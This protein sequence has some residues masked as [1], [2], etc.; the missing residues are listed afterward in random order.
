MT[1]QEIRVSGLLELYLIGALTEEE[2]AI[3]EETL[4]EYPQLKDDLEEIS[5]TLEAYARLHQ[6]APSPS[7]KEGLLQQIKDAEP[8]IPPRT[9]KPV[10]SAKD[11]KAKS[12]NASFKWDNAF[13]WPIAA[14]LFFI[15]T[16]GLLYKSWSENIKTETELLSFQEQIKACEEE[17]AGIQDQLYVFE[18]IKSADNRIV[19]A[20]PSKKYPQ[21]SLIIYDNKSAGKNYLQISQLPALASNQSFQLWSLKE[22]RDPMPLDVFEPGENNIIEVRHVLDSDAYAITIEPKGGSTTPTLSELIGVFN[23]NS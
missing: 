15:T 18:A 22:D 14:S 16:A 23:L 4:I 7:L 8:V 17:K 6:V 1:L 13:L 3:V 9:R 19:T 2:N 21:A 10:K 11:K 20:E 12:S 5:Q